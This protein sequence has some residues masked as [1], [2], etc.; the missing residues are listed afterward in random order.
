MFGLDLITANLL[1]GTFGSF[2]FMLNDH[3]RD[4]KRYNLLD[5]GHSDRKLAFFLVRVDAQL[6]KPTVSIKRF[7]AVE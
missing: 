3:R 1:F 5:Y 4:E 2:V 7:N 6:G